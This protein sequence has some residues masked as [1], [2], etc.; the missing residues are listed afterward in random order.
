[1]ARETLAEV[2]AERDALQKQ[3]EDFKKEVVDVTLNYDGGCQS[4]KE[5]FLNEL[6]LINRRDLEFDVTF[7]VRF[8]DV[9]DAIGV[10]PSYLVQEWIHE[11][12]GNTGSDMYVCGAETDWNE[13]YISVDFDAIDTV[14]R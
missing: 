7:R 11:V 13:H 10:T 9:S 12:C 8:Q 5:E 14:E 6:G 1:M 3:L 2:R 4:G